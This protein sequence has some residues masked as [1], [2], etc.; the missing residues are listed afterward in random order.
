MGMDSRKL[1]KSQRAISVV[2]W[3]QLF[4]LGSS[5]IHIPQYIEAFGLI[6]T[7]G[8]FLLI[9]PKKSNYH[10][11]SYASVF[12]VTTISLEFVSAVISQTHVA[13]Q[14]YAVAFIVFGVSL[15][16][17]TQSFEELIDGFRIAASVIL[18]ISF[19]LNLT[20]QE[21]FDLP[22]SFSWNLLRIRGSGMLAHPNALGLLATLV[23]LTTTGL[24][25]TSLRKSFV[26]TI[27]LLSIITLV[28]TEYR[29]GML[30]CAAIIGA[31]WILLGLRRKNYLQVLVL[32]VCGVGVGLFS[33]IL[34]K[35]RSSNVDL[36]TGRTG[37]W[38]QCLTLIQNQPF[39]GN[40]PLTMER[41]YGGST[42]SSISAYHCHNQFLDHWVNFGKLGLLEMG[43]FF[44][45]LCL[46]AFKSRNSI[47]L[48]LSFGLVIIS[49][50]ESPFRYWS[51]E[52]LQWQNVFIITAF[53]SIAKP[54]RRS[55]TKVS[56]YLVKANY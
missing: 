51:P 50:F 2:L 34:S 20:G 27:Q 29:G 10:F 54:L 1:S 33:G 8:I 9:V 44:F 49:L 45:L 16:V 46:A 38:N 14:R 6:V 25:H 15:V 26:R 52:D 56:N 30:A 22:S 32:T 47:A 35:T 5:F 7:S 55:A 18:G 42:S 4:D 19:I 21:V 24:F 12:L 39:L 53:L 36:T 41:F 11:L 17:G 13:T 23:L 43:I 37:I 31:D 48:K 40:G 3:L 28:T